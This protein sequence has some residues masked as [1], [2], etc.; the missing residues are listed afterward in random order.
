M[1]GDFS[2]NTYR[3]A[4]L[5][6]RVMMQ[7]GRVQIDADWNEQTSI[8]L[9][10]M[11]SLTRD[12][13]GEAAG[14]AIECGFQIVTSISD[15]AS[16]SDTEKASLKAIGINDT[17]TLNP[18]DML[19]MPGRYYVGGIPVETSRAVR[20]AEQLG[21]S[22]EDPFPRPLKDESWVAY[23]D[24]WED[25]VS[26]DQDSHVR[27][28]A[29]GGADTC[30]R[31]RVN[32]RVRILFKSKKETFRSLER[33][34]PGQVKVVAKRVSAEE[35]LCSINP[36]ARYHG[37]ENQLYRI[38]IQTGSSQGNTPTFKWSRDNGSVTFPVAQAK[39]TT[40]TLAHLGRDEA[41]G[42]VVGDCVEL[43]DDAY[44]AATGGVGP[45]AQVSSI[46]PHDLVVTLKLPASISL[47]DYTE[48]DANE[49]HALLRRWDHK[50]KTAERGNGAITVT[51][52]SEIELEDGIFVTF[53]EGDFRPG[54]YWCVPARVLSG[55]VEW[56]GG[57]RAPDGPYHFYA[58]LAEGN[59]TAVDDKRSR[60][61]P[62]PFA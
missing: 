61:K 23:L 26:S 51:W 3:P 7:Q 50:N 55:D 41:N 25:Y 31:A 12:L 60:I 22:L 43:I 15:P 52:D 62:P 16:L 42:L 35:A 9:G 13:F 33:N 49:L 1:K 27:D 56:E 46:D 48:S 20:Y 19:I 57:F 53:K 24:V 11:R 21:A 6:S 36:E 45:L 10:Y 34:N 54:D 14:P 58:Q 5:Y 59:T 47:R 29:L 18:N 38:E 30:G 40:M 32:W 8:L 44:M 39:G 28:I 37:V 17:K 4:S 2:R